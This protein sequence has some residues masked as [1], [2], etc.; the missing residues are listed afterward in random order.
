[1]ITCIIIEDQPPA[2]R[3]LQQYI[4][5]IGT[6]D[7]RGTFGDAISALAYLK[8]T[9][10]ELLFLD[11]HL[12]KISGIDFLD[13]LSPKPKVILTTAFSDYALQGYELDVVD[14]LL[15]PFSFQRFLKAIAKVK[16][17]VDPSSGGALPAEQQLD[18]LF[19]KSNQ[20]YIKVGKSEI[21][22][23]KADGDYTWVFTASSKYIVSHSLRYWL[24]QLPTQD[25]CQIHKSYIVHVAFI[26]KISGN[27]VFIKD[28]VLPIGRTFRDAFFAKYLGGS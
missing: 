11:V 4:Q 27:Q 25:F 28:M 19:I 23:I 5:E 16:D 8:K 14:Y 15:K 26:R 17:P 22:Y 21:Q 20:E 18:Y 1:M 6:L 3:I 2:Q 10:V 7:L 9:P 12:P 24:Q 13:I